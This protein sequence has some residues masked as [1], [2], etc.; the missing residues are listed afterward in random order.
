MLPLTGLLR[1]AV[2]KVDPVRRRGARPTHLPIAPR[3]IPQIEFSK[4]K[5]AGAVAVSSAMMRAGAAL[6][7]PAPMDKEHHPARP[8]T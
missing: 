7:T 6:S 2:G 8:K 4:Q 1:A 5:S 3:P